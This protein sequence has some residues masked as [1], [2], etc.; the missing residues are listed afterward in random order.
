MYIYIFFCISAAP[1]PARGT[2][3][4]QV[5]THLGIVRIYP[6]LQTGVR[7]DRD[8]HIRLICTATGRQGGSVEASKILDFL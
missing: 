5:A 7:F 4:F 2:V 3:L 8:R 1:G 6:D